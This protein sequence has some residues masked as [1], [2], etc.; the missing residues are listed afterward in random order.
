MILS[1]VRRFRS[2]FR[3]AFSAAA[4]LALLG[5]RF[6]GQRAAAQT[7]VLG[8]ANQLEGPT[9]GVESVVLGVTPATQSWVVT[10]NDSW[11]HLA[12]AAGDGVGSTNV[13]FNFDANPGGTRT[14]TLTIAGLTLAITQAGASYIPANPLTTLVSAGLNN[15]EG[16]AVD[17]SGNVYISDTYNNAIKMWTAASDTVSTLVSTGLNRPLGLA[18]DHAGNVYIADAFNNAI[19]MWTAV[20]GVVTALVPLGLAYP[21]GVAVDAA[22]NVYIADYFD[23]AMKQW[24]AASGIVTT[25]ASGLDYP[26]GVAVDAAGNVYITGYNDGTLKR[27]SAANGTVETLISPQLHGP[28]GVAVDAAGN[29]YIANY[30]STTITKWTAASGL[31]S[32]LVAS[33]LA[34]PAGVAVDLAGNVFIAA[35]GNG[36][37]YG[38]PR[39]FVDATA[40]MEPAAAGSDTLPAVLPS[41]ANLTGPFAPTSDSAWLTI[42][43]STNGVVSFSFAANSTAAPRTA[44]LTVLGESIPITQTG[45]VLAPILTGARVLPN[46]GFQFKFSGTPGAAYTVLS[47]TNLALPT[48]A[49]MT[50]GLAV[51]SPAGQFQFTASPPLGGGPHFFQVRF[52]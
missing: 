32:S 30:F 41:T 14:G 49:W 37:V 31:V 4:L 48:T 29:V 40:K 13:V 50:A 15:P 23:G 25:L 28:S 27:W 34:S 51:E 44:Q 5:L 6:G 24:G 22:G 7:F 10:A 38:L 3:I 47:T 42:T 35:P 12:R 33:A 16:V 45:A 9:G 18:V 8:T 19:K 39:A 17:G 20:S 11:L 43:G 26:G 2:S 1:W 46:G 36:T 21:D 52:P